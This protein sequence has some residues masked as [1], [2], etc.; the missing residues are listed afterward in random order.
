MKT[1]YLFLSLVLP[2]SAQASLFDASDILPRNSGAVSVLG[3]MILND[4]TSEGVEARARYG[5][6][7]EWNVGATLGTGSDGKSTRIGAEAVYSILPDWEGQI[8]LSALGGATILNRFGSAGLLMRTALMAHKKV[9][10]WGGLPASVYLGIPFQIEARKGNYTTGW[11]FILGSLFDI[12][13]SGRFYMGL[14]GGV[15]LSKSESF[16]LVGAGLRLG[17]LRFERKRSG[18]SSSGTNRTSTQDEYTDEDFQ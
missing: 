2:L 8:G 14:E 6:S 9:T 5:L 11:Q 16:V 17:D 12:E 7:A 10:G 1:I 18:G 15:S 3:E 13:D 4:P